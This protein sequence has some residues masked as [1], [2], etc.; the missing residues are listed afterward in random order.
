[1]DKKI[2]KIVKGY[3]PDAQIISVGGILKTIKNGG[4]VNDNADLTK[5]LQDVLSI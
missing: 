1:M 5:E 2:I 3:Y 4:L